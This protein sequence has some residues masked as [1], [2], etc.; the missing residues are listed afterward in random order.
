MN[1][2][3]AMNL[4]ECGHD[5]TILECATR[6]ELR[7]RCASRRCL[8]SFLQRSSSDEDSSGRTES[9]AFRRKGVTT[10]QSSRKFLV[11]TEA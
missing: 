3:L 11:C 2:L 9:P 7:P 8:R 4:S 6:D 10:N 5:S 1:H